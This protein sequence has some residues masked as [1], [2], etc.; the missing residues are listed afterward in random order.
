MWLGD[1][2]GDAWNR[3]ANSPRGTLAHSD[4]D[5]G[6]IF[7]WRVIKRLFAYILPY[8]RHA[9]LGVLAMFILQ[10]TQIAQ[11]LLEGNA[12]DKVVAGD[13]GGLFTVVAIYLGTLF[14]AWMAQ[15]Q[16]VYQMSWA[17]QHVLYQVAS[18]MFK[19]IVRL[20]VSFFDEN[21]TGRI[22]SRVQSDVNILQ[23][24]LSSGLIQTLGNMLLLV[25]IVVTMFAVNWKLAALSTAVIPLFVFLIIIWQSYA[26]RSF[27]GARAAI[28]VVSAN[29]QENVSGVRVIQSMGREDQN[30]EEFERANAENLRANL[31]A[32]KVGSMTQPMV[33]IISAMSL[34][35]VVFFGG[36]MVIQDTLSIGL[37]YAFTRYVNRFFEPLRMLTQEYNQLQRAAVAAE[38]IFEVLDTEEEIK[39]APDAIDLPQIEGRIEYADV[40]FAYVP[41]AIVL[42]DFS[43]DVAPGER[44]AFVGQTGAGK[45]TIISLLL[46]FYDVTSGRILIDGHDLREVK[47]ES[48]RRQI[49]IVLQEPVLFTGSIADNIR[50]AR[51]SASD[52][53]VE[54]AARAVGADKMI[55]RLEHSYKTEVNERGLGLSVGER[56]LIAF[57]R[58][59]FGDPRVLIL[60]EATANLDTTTELMVQRGIRT[61]T[62]G[63]TS[64]IIAHRLSTIRDADR[65]VV[66]E[67]GRIAEVG[68]HEELIALGGVYSRLYSL[69][70]QQRA[71]QTVT[72]G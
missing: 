26:R 52:A 45:S 53:E 40:G 20:S 62:A 64:L 43:L 68:N 19:H 18:D 44:L 38:R 15:Y 29:L 72:R 28:S 13:L 16:Q 58:A 25:G 22:M 34:A 51:P 31:Y 21:E 35:I 59:L 6:K 67:Q 11:P 30:F 5:T 63:R 2:P 48:L 7:D 70:F 9:L 39:D 50:Y 69:G 23:Q 10:A 54:A 46:R 33:E 27:R 56:Q 57:A 14:V 1:R 32:T 42:K 65:I 55:Q 24:L 47:M 66:L 8:R 3:A 61:L 17:G 37:L 41:G 71:T 49:G 36:S 12:I 60:D 4:E